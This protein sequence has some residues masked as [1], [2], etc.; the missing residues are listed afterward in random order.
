M[1][2]HPTSALPLPG[3][4][5][6]PISDYCRFKKIAFLYS[7]PPGILSRNITRRMIILQTSDLE[8][9]VQN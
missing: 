5:E 6:V 2:T 8:T 4:G 7:L 1:D 9:A 3:C